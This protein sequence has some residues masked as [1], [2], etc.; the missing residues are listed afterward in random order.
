MAGSELVAVETLVPAV[1]FGDGGVDKILADVEAL[2][3]AEKVD[4]S[5]APGRKACA[6]LAHKVARSKTALDEMGKQLTADLKAQTGRVDAERRK[7]RDR[8]DALKDEVRKPLTDWENAE[9]TRVKGHEA[10]VAAILALTTF[11]YITPPSQE[12]QAR[13][14]DLDGHLDRDWQEFSARAKDMHKRTGEWLEQMLATALKR[15]ADAAELEQRHKEDAERRR[16]EHEDQIASEAAARA[17]KRAEENAEAARVA[18]EKR[19]EKDRAAVARAEAEA[20]AA[21]ERAARAVEDERRRVA[22][23]AAEAARQA[24]AREQNKKHRATVNTAAML[25]LVKAGLSES[26]AK[27][28]VTAIAKGEVPGVSINY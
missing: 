17:V 7:I 20:A 4:I 16:K 15:E 25:A 18:A 6:S 2:A 19:A 3:R 23:E 28:A 22:A 12:I 1:V 24:E 11:P 5:T 26:A 10:A 13:I 14:R 8:L 9:A 21:D 27:T